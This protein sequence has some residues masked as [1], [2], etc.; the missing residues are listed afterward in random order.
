MINYR[1][2]GQILELM[3]T[4]EYDASASDQVLTTIAQDPTIRWP[5]YLLLHTAD[6][7]HDLSEADIRT[8]LRNLARRFGGKLRRRCAVVSPLTDM[9]ARYFQVKAADADLFQIRV[10]ETL[11]AARQWL[12]DRPAEDDSDLI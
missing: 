10:F 11:D 7:K 2:D 4:G 9:A 1:V 8:R 6:L 3:V 5:M 12:N